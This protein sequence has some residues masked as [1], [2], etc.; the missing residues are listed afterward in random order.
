MKQK[1]VVGTVSYL[2]EKVDGLLREGWRMIPESL[3]F[4]GDE[5]NGTRM[6]VIL[7]RHDDDPSDDCG[8]PLNDA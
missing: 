3:R 6:A 8:E 1:L 4:T 2:V 5:R 7:E